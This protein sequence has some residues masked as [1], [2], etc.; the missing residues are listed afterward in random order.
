MISHGGGLRSL[1]IFLKMGV[2][3]G[4]WKCVTWILGVGIGRILDE[5]EKGFEAGITIAF[6]G[7]FGSVSEFGQKGKDL[8]WGEGIHLS[9]TKFSLELGKDELIVLQCIFFL[10]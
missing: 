7:L 5:I 8:I 3:H 6:G 1:N 2:S 10:N 4:F 9:I